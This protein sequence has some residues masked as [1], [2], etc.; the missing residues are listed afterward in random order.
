MADKEVK[1]ENATVEC[2]AQDEAANAS[3]MEGQAGEPD[4]EGPPVEQEVDVIKAESTVS[5]SD[6]DEEDERSP[7]AEDTPGN[8]L[9]DEEGVVSDE[10]G[11][12]TAPPEGT[13]GNASEEGAVNN[14][15]E[16]DS[17]PV[18]EEATSGDVDE[19][20]DGGPVEPMAEE[21]AVEEA[22]ASTPE[23]RLPP[24]PKEESVEESGPEGETPPQSELEDELRTRVSVLE[25]QL[26]E[27]EERAK[28]SEDELRS[29]T[30]SARVASTRIGELEEELKENRQKLDG[31]RQLL[32]SQPSTAPAEIPLDVS[33]LVAEAWKQEQTSL[34]EDAQELADTVSGAEIWAARTGALR[35]A[36]DTTVTAAGEALEACSKIAEELPAEVCDELQGRQEGLNLTGKMLSR[37]PGRLP[38]K[39]DIVAEELPSI[40]ETGWHDLLTGERREES[41]RRRIKQEAGRVGSERYQVIS[42]VRS[43]GEKAQKSAL[44]VVEKHVL[45][46][47][48]AIDDGESHSTP[49]IAELSEKYPDEK[50]CLDAWCKTYA[51]LRGLL[52]N[53]LAEVGVRPMEVT[54]GTHVDY[55]RHEPFDV[56]PDPELADESIK[57]VVR[58]G[59]EYE[60]AGGE[61]CVLRP[62]QVVAVKNVTVTPPVE[63]A[64]AVET[65]DADGEPEEPAVSDTE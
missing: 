37:L 34:E 41:A 28:Q 32:A 23:E 25:S 3:T 36:M 65:D 63:E 12:D 53:A 48:D 6:Q 11:A 51:E 29:S 14:E 62:A 64:D 27:A 16:M 1:R 52:L 56:E 43:A 44:G 31:I 5:E 21:S 55:D 47:L 24:V 7:S 22:E 30:A 59:Y 33:W 15:E 2:D 9:G 19:V 58:Q 8:V 18:A 38:E 4:R 49:L 40:G 35:S 17:A 45:P 42:R 61:S 46:V 26:L 10:E 39:A 20:S 50:E 60:L 57:S 13:P 54:I